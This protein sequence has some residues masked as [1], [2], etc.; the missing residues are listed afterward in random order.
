MARSSRISLPLTSLAI[1]LA[2]A[3]APRASA[4]GFQLR[5]QS[6]S[7]Q[8]NAYAGASAGGAD[9]SSMFFNPATL[10][11]YEGDQLQFGLTEILPSSK[12]SDGVSSRTGSA[13]P[14]GGAASTGNVAKSATLPTLYAMWSL[15]NDLKLGISVNVPFGLTTQYDPN[16]AGRYLAVKSHLETLDITPTLAYRMTPKWSMGVALVARR[17]KAELSQAIDSGYA[18]QTALQGAH[19]V[20]P[21]NPATGQPIVSP[22]A[23]TDGFV[24]VRGSSWAYGY[25]LGL[26]YEPSASIHLGLG[27]QSEIRETIKGSATFTTP[28]IPAQVPAALQ[29]AN[30]G[31]LPGTV[32]N[33]LTSLALAT[34][35]NSASAVVNLPATISLGMIYD[36]SSTFSLAAEI[37]DTKWSSFKEL[38]VK[39]NNAATQPDQYTTENWKDA[40]FVAL[41]AT[42]KPGNAWTYRVGVALDNTPVPDANRTPRIPDADRFWISGGVGYQF[43]KSFGMDAGYS[44][45]ICKN[46]TVN[47][48]SGSDPTDQGKFFGGNLS[49]TYKNT[50]DILAVQA[51]YTF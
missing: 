42:C 8:G 10:T 37:S 46:S 35:N 20:N 43:T 31:A 4:S 5:D 16:W 18:A 2:A 24:D 7:G 38:R 45:L 47:L 40:L 17:A 48:Q 50:I 33:V 39:F 23:G 51:R 30:P 6:G 21:T 11:R 29:A 14:V 3:V 27:Y 1:L 36:V 34:T 41:G 26:I 49:G 9:I 44:H 15:D 28:A 19:L 12:F 32:N 25:K 13:V 22:G